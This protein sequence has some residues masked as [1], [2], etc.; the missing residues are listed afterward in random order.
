MTAILQTEDLALS[1]KGFFAV[2]GVNLSVA[3]NSIH[4]VI[5]PNGAGKTSLFNMLAGHYP[6]SAGRVR[7]DGHD[8]TRLPAH[9]RVGRGLARCFQVTNLFNSMSV[10]EN[11]MV[12]AQ[13]RRAR[14][15]LALWRHADGFRGAREVADEVIDRLKLEGVADTLAGALSHGQQRILEV[16][17]ALAGRPRVLLLDEPTSGMGVDDLP[18]MQTVIRDLARDHTVLLV[19]HNMHIVMSI[20]DRITVMFQGQV[21]VEGPPETIRASE[22]VRQVYL[23]GSVDTTRRPAPC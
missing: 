6:P 20:S 7:L 19:E 23:G 1:F 14:G 17:M 3:P 16:G 12:A 10:R 18:R 22:E 9:K 11:L 8:I 13:G 5:G 4:A 15:A 21:L 2:S